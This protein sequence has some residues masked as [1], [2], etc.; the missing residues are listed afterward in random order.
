MD[1]YRFSLFEALT[2]IIIDENFQAHELLKR[3]NLGKSEGNGRFALEQNEKKREVSDRKHDPIQVPRVSQVASMIDDHM[4]DENHVQ[5][6]MAILTSHAHPLSESLRRFLSFLRTRNHFSIWL[7]VAFL[8]ILLLMQLS[9]IMLLTRA[10]QYN[11]ISQLEYGRHVE[12]KESGAET[13]AWFEKRITYLKE[14]MMMVEARLERMLLE[15]AMLKAQLKS[16]KE[17]K[18]D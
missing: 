7:V 6:D 17:L 18:R 14:E 11:I 12:S 9:I 2:G 4:V 5:G 8:L 15:H 16:L 3:E 1:F 13:I 10:P